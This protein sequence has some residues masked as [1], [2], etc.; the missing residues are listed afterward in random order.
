MSKEAG[1]TLKQKRADKHPKAAA[2]SK[3]EIV[4]PGKRRS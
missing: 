1:K 2:K 3:T 4:P